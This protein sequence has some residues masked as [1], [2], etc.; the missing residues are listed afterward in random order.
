VNSRRED[1]LVLKS[2]ASACK[3]CLREVDHFGRLGGEEFGI[4]L[5]STN[6]EGA[7][8]LAERIRL[9]V[10]ATETNWNETQLHI[11]GS[12][13]VTEITEADA[14]FDGV[15]LRADEALYQAK[16]QG[17]NRTHSAA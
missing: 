10:A 17:R 9:C 11:T 1:D 8:Q 3:E 16:M 13:G 4:L 14:N 15:Y 2:F 5:P 12:F 7:V 6:L